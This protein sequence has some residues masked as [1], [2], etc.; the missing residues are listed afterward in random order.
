MNAILTG[1]DADCKPWPSRAVGAVA[2]TATAASDTR[3][4]RCIMLELP[5]EDVGPSLKEIAELEVQLPTGLGPPEGIDP[6]EAVGV[7][8]AE[9]SERRD[10]GRPDPGAAEQPGG[11]ELRGPRPDVAGV[12]ERREIQHLRHAH[13]ELARHREER[14]PERVG[15]RPVGAGVGVVTERRD[16]SLVVAAERD[17]ELRAAEGEQLLEEWRVAEHEPG[18]RREAEHELDGGRRRIAERADRRVKVPLDIG[19]LEVARPAEQ[20]A[21]LRESELDHRASR[22]ER[23]VDPGVP[24]HRRAERRAHAVVAAEGARERR[25]RGRAGEAL[26]I[27][28]VRQEQPRVIVAEHRE[29]QLQARAAPPQAADVGD[30][31]P[32]PRIVHAERRGDARFAHGGIGERDVE[33][34]D[35]LAEL[36][37]EPAAL[38]LAKQVRLV[39][40]EEAADP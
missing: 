9:R 4:R 5:M 11:I 20:A 21:A 35:V 27:D 2:S 22:G 39:E 30:D 10:D 7:I 31:V 19:P 26:L 40:A 24:H 36:P 17:E 8:D 3:T 38:A 34:V 16:R 25:V 6:I 13:P 15:A 28:A 14:L 1:P 18:P 12:E 29:A 23:E 33:I 32:H 37:L